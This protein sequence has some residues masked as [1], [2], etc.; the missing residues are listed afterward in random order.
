MD[1][2]RRAREMFRAL[3]IPSSKQITEEVIDELVATLSRTAIERRFSSLIDELQ[4]Q[5]YE[6]YLEC[7]AQ[8]APVKIAE[9]LIRAKAARLSGKELE[10]L[11]RKRFFTLDRFFLSLTQSRRNRAG[12]AF[13]VIVQTL[14]QRLGYPHTPQPKLD[15]Q[16]DF[17]FPDERHYFDDALDCLV[18]TVKRSLRE[19]WKQILAE[20]AK[21][22]MFYLATIDDKVSDAQLGYM[23]ERKVYL[24]V[25]KSLADAKYRRKRNVIS[26][27]TFFRDHL[28]PAI[29]RW[30][31]R[32]VV[33]KAKNGWAYVPNE[34]D[35]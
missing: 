30:S 9:M 20:G 27:E 29:R 25:P 19:R 8:R 22:P 23:H 18:F 21:G 15:G 4:I 16:P 14:M 34:D 12:D 17:V 24:V 32:G 11:L 10:R 2:S 33:G 13:Q 35:E 5:A 1:D 3:K 6:R 7:E 31:R 28:D 26:F